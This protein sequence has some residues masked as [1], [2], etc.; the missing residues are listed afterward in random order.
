VYGGFPAVSPTAAANGGLTAAPAM[1]ISAHWRRT[2]GRTPKRLRAS[3]RDHGAFPLERRSPMPQLAK[4]VP[5]NWSRR[6]DT[7][8]F[9]QNR[10]QPIR[11]L[12]DAATFVASLPKAE[13]Q[14]KRWKTAAKALLL[15]AEHGGDLTPTRV[16]IL[17]A[18][19]NRP[20]LQASPKRRARI[21]RIIR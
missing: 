1:P 3:G 6:F 12:N 8:I 2:G 20:E 18:L 11:S 4:V 7:P 9:I 16:A 17:H 14:S 19:H 21:V 13:Q 10:Q 5:S 15:N